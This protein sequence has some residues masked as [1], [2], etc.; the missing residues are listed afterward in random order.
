MSREFEQRL[1]AIMYAD[2]AGYSRLTGDD[3][4]ATHRSLRESLDLLSA[5]IES[6]GG[7]VVH[8]AG[9]AILARFDTVT[10]AV[11]SAVDIQQEIRARNEELPAARKLYFRI[12]INIGEVIFDRDD[13]Y[14]D[15]VNIAARLESLAEPGGICVSRAVYDSVYSR[16]PFRFDYMG[17]HKVKNIEREVR[18]YRVVFDSAGSADKSTASRARTARGKAALAVAAAFVLA[19]GAILAWWLSGPGKVPAGATT[20]ATETAEASAQ[21]LSIA[22]L[23]FANLSGDSEQ[24][25][26]SDGITNDIITDLSQ[27]S[28]LPVI[29]SNSVFVYKNTPVKVQQV[30]RDLGVSHVLE[31]SVQKSGNKVRINVQLIDASNGHH[32]WAERFDREILDIFQLQDEVS[33]KIVDQ[34]AVSLTQ[35][36]QRLLERQRQVDPEAYDVL[37][38]GLALVRRF[39]RETNA[40]SRQYFKRAIEFDPQFARAY[41]DVAFT[42]AL[43]ILFGWQEASEENFRTAFEYADKAIALDDSIGQ[44]HFAR[45]VLLLAAR[46]HDEAIEASKRSVAQHPNYADGWAEYAQALI[47]AGRLEEGLEKMRIAMQLNPRHAFFYTWI[48]GNAKMLQGD[49][50][51]AETAFLDVVE[52]NPH[53]IG[54]HLTLASLYGN[55]G[56][57]DE[58]QWSAA[59]VLTLDPDLTL[60]VEADRVPYL[61]PEH[62]QFYIE[63][64]RRAGIPE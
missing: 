45:S 31:G 23:P 55:Q 47:Y 57:I 54:A 58:A 48:E 14:G 63:G 5:S 33:R 3:E 27:V 24:E 62:L 2:V 50:A 17:R 42:Y 46:R 40:E 22:V 4:L 32:L 11:T 35:G 16:V 52:R 36:E 7:D 18:C 13:I 9:D 37:L 64:L 34:L 56:H 10:D 20:Q 41:A 51:A 39:T 1:V 53:F 59:E 26:F 29:A 38:Q 61:Q 21:R 49:Y 30:A 25:Y 6:H 8:Y 19:C 15:G 28:G 43:D 60:S 44:V 12:G